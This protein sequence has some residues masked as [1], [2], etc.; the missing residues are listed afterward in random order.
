MHLLYSLDSIH[1]FSTWYQSLRASMNHLDIVASAP[2]F[3]FF[4]FSNL[5]AQINPSPTD[6]QNPICPSKFQNHMPPCATRRLCIQIHARLHHLSYGTTISGHHIKHWTPQFDRSTTDLSNT[7]GIEATRARLRL[8]VRADRISNSLDPLSP[9]T[10]IRSQYMRYTSD[11]HPT[12]QDPSHRV[13]IR[14]LFCYQ[15]FFSINYTLNLREN[16]KEWIS[17]CIDVWICVLCYPINR[18]ASNTM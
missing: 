7:T 4:F 16:V 1:F 18:I 8:H 9:R 11:T 6:Q 13:K 10:N 14:A 3:F 12:R 2:I 17:H 5:I 15:I